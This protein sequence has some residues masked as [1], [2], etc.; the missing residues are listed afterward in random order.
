[1]MPN[2]KYILFK[3][4]FQMSKMMND[5]SIYVINLSMLSDQFIF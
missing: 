1:M 2:E 5:Q 4:R 3:L